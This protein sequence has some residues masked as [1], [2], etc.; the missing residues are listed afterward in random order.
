[1]LSLL[2]SV[3]STYDKSLIYLSSEL[4]KEECSENDMGEKND[5]GLP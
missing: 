3:N 5:E 4:D 2:D 1:M